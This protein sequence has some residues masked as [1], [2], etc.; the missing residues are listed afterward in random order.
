M[1][2]ASQFDL[3]RDS[4]GLW[5]AHPREVLEHARGLEA[6]VVILKIVDGVVN[7]PCKDAFGS[8]FVPLT[9]ITNRGNDTRSLS[10]L[11]SC[12]KGAE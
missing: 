12:T 7:S 5:I 3:N 1:H 6:K 2:S 4:S 9:D 10:E 11:L 8:H